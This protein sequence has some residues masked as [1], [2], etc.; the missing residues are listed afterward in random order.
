DRVE[1]ALTI[2]EPSCLGLNVLGTPAKDH[3][4]EHTGRKTIRRYD[5]PALSPGKAEALARQG[6]AGKACPPTDAGGRELIQR[7]RVT[8][9]GSDLR[10]RGRCQEA[11]EGIV[12]RTHL[13][14][15]QA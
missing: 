11:E 3:P 5:G 2:L 9:A 7:D 14:V 6:Q 12:A 10:V 8:E 4:R 1:N 15:R 13:G